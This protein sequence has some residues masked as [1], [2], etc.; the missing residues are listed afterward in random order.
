M[1]HASR[2]AMCHMTPLSFQGAKMF[3]AQH[4][5]TK[6]SNRSTRPRAS[7][8]GHQALQSTRQYV[9]DKVMMEFKNFYGVSN[10]KL[11]HAFCYLK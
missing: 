1:M 10:H 9:M 6:G 11:R 3:E 7:T 8:T 2:I 4:A 5:S